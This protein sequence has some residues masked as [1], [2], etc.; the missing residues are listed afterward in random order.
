M[1]PVTILLS[2]AMN[3]GG[4]MTT[5]NFGRTENYNKMMS[6]N[7]VKFSKSCHSDTNDNCLRMQAYYN[8][9]LYADTSVRRTE[10]SLRRA[11]AVQKFYS[12]VASCL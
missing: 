8:E 7:S 9:L 3:D 12:T 6:N 1:E 4:L 2:T 5:S 11:L 10:T